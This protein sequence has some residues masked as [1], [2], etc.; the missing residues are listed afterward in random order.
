MRYAGLALAFVSSWC[1][2]FSGPM[3]KFLNAAGL[4]PLESVWLRMSGAGLLMF[5]L[6]AVFK[7]AVLRIPRSKWGFF[8]AYALVAVAGVQTLYF[9]AIT[10]LPVGI[11]LL[12]EFTAPVM[13]VFWV[14]FVR[15]VRLPRIAF[16]GAILAFAGLGVVVEFWEGMRLDALGVVLGLAAGA[17]CAAYFLLSDSIGDGVSPLGLVAWGMLGAA[18]LLVPLAQP[19]NIPWEAFGA[20]A[21]IGGNT[22]PVV[23][24][25]L[26][27]IVVATAVAYVLG[28][29]AV[30]RLS[31]AIGATVATLEVI[32]GAIV[33]WLLLGEDL[34]P[35]QIGG[36]LAVL[37]GALLAQLSTARSAVREPEREPSVTE[38]AAV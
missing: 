25:Y 8:A 27:M 24:A 14:R 3:A 17:C 6:L 30:R 34:G 19:W 33:A 16:A 5:A 28:V 21:T 29:N 13:V 4:A 7:P 18:V 20:S 37:A 10:R 38:P 31:A 12:L 1:F 23:G 2:A 15:K 32:F 11:A 35:F 26:W 22:L 9:V 36:G